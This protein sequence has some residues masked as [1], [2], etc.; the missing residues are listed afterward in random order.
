MS[1]GEKNCVY[2][3]LI[4]AP[5]VREQSSI[6]LIQSDVDEIRSIPCLST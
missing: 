2:L 4:E 3:S 6:A 1:M 5:E